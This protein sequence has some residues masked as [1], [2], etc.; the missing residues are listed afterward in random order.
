MRSGGGAGHVSMMSSLGVQSD[1]Q[2]GLVVS[3]DR[4]G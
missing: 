1:R 2:Y 3:Q 4:N